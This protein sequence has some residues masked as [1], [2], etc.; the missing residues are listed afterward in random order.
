[1]KES[2]ALVATVLNRSNE[3]IN[4]SGNTPF[5]EVLQVRLSR[6]Q[7][8]KGGLGAAASGM[9]GLSLA[10]CQ[11]GMSNGTLP[12]GEGTLLPD[13]GTPPPD[14]GTPP[15]GGGT[16]PS[17]G[18]TQPPGGDT[19]VEPKLAFQAISTA[20]RDSVT[21]PHGYT[22]KAFLPWGTPICGSYPAY[23]PDGTNTG[24]E[25]EQQIGMCH[26]GIH[27]FPINGSSAHGLLVIN[28][29]YTVENVLH[30][31]GPT[32]V[33][34][35][36]TVPDQ[37]RKEIAAHGVSV[38]EIQKNTEGEWQLVPSMYNRRITGATPMTIQGPL[39]GNAKLRTKYSPDGTSTR[40]TLNNCARGFTPWN[41]YL[42]CEENWH[43]YFVH[44]GNNRGREYDRYGI[45]SQ[46]GGRRWYTADDSAP[47]LVAAHGVDAFRRF[48]C[49][50]VSGAPPT[51]DYRHEVH[52]FGW[53]VEVDPFNPDSIPVKRTALGRFRHEGVVIA[54]VEEGKPLVY[55]AGDDAPN[56]YIY[57]FVT[58]AN[59]HAATASG[60]MLDEGTLYVARFDADGSGRWLALDINDP[61]FQAACVAKG[62]VFADQA[63][64]LLNTRTAADAVGG[65][66]MDR[67]EWGA[68]HPHTG[69]VY[70]TLTNNLNRSAD[71]ADAANPRGPNPY[72]HIIR[73]QED[74]RGSTA[75]TFEWDIF[76]LAGP[77]DD[78]GIFGDSTRRLDDSNI[79][80]SPDGLWIDLN[81]ILWIQTDM[82]DSQQRG[83]PFGENA[84]L[85]AEPATGEIR[86]FL[87]GPVNQEVTGVIMTP[88]M[89]TMFV[90]MQHPGDQS[91]PGNFT[92]NWP[93]RPGEIADINPQ[94]PRPRCAT[95]IITKNDGGV[96]GL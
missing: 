4:P 6:R 5:S 94:G 53:V 29:E 9:F 27:Y 68:V 17:D 93:D 8:L 10:G 47:A 1:L 14:R 49:T 59:Y 42:T 62:V 43:E 55:F 28:H 96:I 15:P 20:R 90:N 50:P 26:D 95:V 56:E 30:A 7:V 13:R 92:S 33:S 64:V 22:A 48:D 51:A 60:S 67:P 2:D 45:P 82:S 19:F 65:T 11:G 70:F 73:W 63:D 80:A 35:V 87:S 31:K 46:N 18:G 72:G 3:T 79:F 41:T 71:G 85:A 76:V 34:G 21:V 77:Q 58:R 25:Q 75:T 24:E 84:M 78:S 89:R 91:R 52:G 36:R 39:R 66:P 38:V 37:V 88:E 74:G 86:R 57:R 54:P 83:G 61:A 44:R 23:R 12:P 81:G 32:T 16:S 69:H 40:G